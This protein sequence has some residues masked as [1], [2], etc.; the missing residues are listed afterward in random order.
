MKTI[1]K[2]VIKLSDLPENLQINEIFIGHKIHT[3]AIFHIDNSEEDELSLWLIEN[4]PTIK[5]KISFLIHIDVE[6]KQSVSTN[7]LFNL[8]NLNKRAISENWKMEDIGEEFF[9]TFAYSEKQ[10]I[11]NVWY[12]RFCIVESQLIEIRDGKD[13]LKYYIKPKINE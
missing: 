10:E 7:L 2:S 1:T 4:Y 6:T 13:A 8:I 3:Y 9:K 11:K 12:D 5:K